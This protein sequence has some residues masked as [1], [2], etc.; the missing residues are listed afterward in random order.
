M[1][2]R[3]VIVGLLLGLAAALL[4][5]QK[6]PSGPIPLPFGEGTAL[7]SSI[8]DIG[9][10]GTKRIKNLTIEDN[11]TS[12]TLQRDAMSITWIPDSSTISHQAELFMALGPGRVFGYKYTSKSAAAEIAARDQAAAGQPKTFAQLFP[13][14]FFTSYSQRID[15]NFITTFESQKGITFL[16]M[17][18]VTLDKNSRYIFVA[19]DDTTLTVRGLT[20]CAD[21]RV[22]SSEQCDDF[23]PFNGDGCSS[24][25]TIEPGY[26]CT[27]QRSVC[28][29]TACTNGTDD[30][31]DGG[32]DLPGTFSAMQQDPG[33]FI[34]AIPPPLVI[35]ENGWAYAVFTIYNTTDKALGV[36]NFQNDGRLE[37][38]LTTVKG[39][40][41]DYHIA[42]K[43]LYVNDFSTDPAKIY[44]VHVEG[45]LTNH[46]G[47]YTGPTGMGH[48]GMHV[49]SM[50]DKF[51]TLLQS[52][53]TNP[54]LRPTP[55]VEEVNATTMMKT[56]EALINGLSGIDGLQ[57]LVFD[58]QRQ[59]LYILDQRNGPTGT[60]GQ[61]SLQIREVD[62]ATMADTGRQFTI[63]GEKMSDW[64]FDPVRGL[65]FIAQNPKDL[66]STTLT[67][68]SVDSFSSPGNLTLHNGSS[69]TFEG[70]SYTMMP[71]NLQFA[72][73]DTKR[74]IATAYYASPPPSP[75]LSPR[76]S[77][78]FFL[79]IDTT[80]APSLTEQWVDVPEFRTSGNPSP[81]MVTAID[82]IRGVV[83]LQPDPVTVLSPM[84][85]AIA[86]EQHR[87]TQKAPIDLMGDTS[88]RGLPFNLEPSRPLSMDSTKKD[89][90]FIPAF[91]GGASY[92]IFPLLRI[93]AGDI[94]C[95]DATDDSEG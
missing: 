72:R 83:Y 19:N 76:W 50:G 12:V 1:S 33:Q 49:A 66:T 80:S 32:I 6:R 45:L 13:G 77:R 69:V 41:G 14:Q 18:D 22:Q 25:C 58:D 70:Q 75:G 36:Y 8:V 74:L 88:K 59:R 10:S 26:V 15:G 39:S 81:H 93:N 24:A 87:V 17:T 34:G 57:I 40:R 7:E 61:H 55:V 62:L 38:H 5:L 42:T 23:N 2:K 46:E 95:T 47:T 51:Y 31:G 82:S 94:G 64:E 68:F 20:L 89:V 67:A 91:V 37:K 4:I 78:S 71:I 90:I 79:I 54:A 44:K 92:D 28:R 29:K 86:P 27:G 21:G 43:K 73:S 53:K 48:W 11:E 16:P 60:M 30:D 63:T 85:L 9:S 35:E 65:L 84:W 52:P 3:I 56:R